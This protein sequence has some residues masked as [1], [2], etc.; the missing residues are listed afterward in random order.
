MDTCH[1][2]CLRFETGL[3]VTFEQLPKGYRPDELRIYEIN[4]EEMNFGMEYTCK[5]SSHYVLALLDTLVHSTKEIS[6]TEWTTNPFK[7]LL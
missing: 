6:T 5:S 1:T 7:V 2:H 4:Q 3:F